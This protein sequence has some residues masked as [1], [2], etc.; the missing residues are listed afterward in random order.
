MCQKFLEQVKS[1]QHFVCDKFFILQQNVLSCREFQH[2]FGIFLEPVLIF[3]SKTFWVPNSQLILIRGFL[4]T[5]YFED[6]RVCLFNF[7]Q[8][9]IQHQLL[10]FRLLM[11]Q[12]LA[13]VLFNK[14][15]VLANE[16][17]RAKLRINK[18][19]LKIEITPKLLSHT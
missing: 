12:M 13:A 7:I 11:A 9:P 14:K 5:P 1:F 18:T 15:K 19:S 4:H 10:S 8:L 6:S 3:L 2:K 16:D 17:R